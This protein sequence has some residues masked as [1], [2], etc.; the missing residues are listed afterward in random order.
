MVAAFGCGPAGFG[1]VGAP[2]R[3][4]VSAEL[5]RLRLAAPSL[6]D[7]F[8]AGVAASFPRGRCLV[9]TACDLHLFRLRSSRCVARTYTHISFMVFQN[10]IM[11]I[12]ISVCLLALVYS[13]LF[14]S[15]WFVQST[16]DQSGSGIDVIKNQERHSTCSTRT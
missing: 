5:V 16:S 2:L 9:C 4:C 7:L 1:L 6:R 3:Y 11:Q 10:G 14:C 15:L 8:C 13:Y 12:R